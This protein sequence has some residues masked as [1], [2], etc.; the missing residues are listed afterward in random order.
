MARPRRG[1]SA[2]GPRTKAIYVN[3]PSNPTGWVMSGEEQK[4]LLGLCRARG[5]GLVADEVY[6][7][8]VLTVADPAPAFLT[9][10]GPEEPVFVLNG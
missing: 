6:H 3:S 2:I 1:E 5:L 4:A 8:N 10:A 7:R 9:L